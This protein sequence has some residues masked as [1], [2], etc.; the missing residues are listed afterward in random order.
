MERNG[1]G[2]RGRGR[3]AGV[4]KYGNGSNKLGYQIK[5]KTEAPM[6]E[7]VP[8]DFPPSN[9]FSLA[10]YPLLKKK[11]STFWISDP[12]YNFL[13]LIYLLY[14]MEMGG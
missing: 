9:F 10:Y 1:G 8:R 11:L 12:L 4:R 14:I 6:A 2:G 3:G 5:E 13:S 7:F